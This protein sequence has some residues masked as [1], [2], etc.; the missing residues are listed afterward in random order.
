M[1]KLPL[2]DNTKLEVASARTFAINGGNWPVY[3]IQN[4]WEKFHELRV[5]NK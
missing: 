4:V 1:L 3:A 2:Q 5:R